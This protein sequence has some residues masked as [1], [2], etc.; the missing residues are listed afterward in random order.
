M[1]GEGYY[2]GFSPAE[3]RG[4]L[5]AVKAALTAGALLPA[6]RCSVCQ[7]SD[8]ALGW[9]SERYDVLDARAVCWRCHLAVHRRFKRP[10][11]WLAYIQPLDPDGW[12]QHLSLD[13]ATLRR[14]FAA[15]Y[16][17]G[18]PISRETGC[19]LAQPHLDEPTGSVAAR[20]QE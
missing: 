4:A 8:K 2:N 20:L 3:R 6:V 1:S 12:F 14:P 16:P 19:P 17:A 15:S 18:L 11:H 9:H 5:K 7:R 13:P 10:A